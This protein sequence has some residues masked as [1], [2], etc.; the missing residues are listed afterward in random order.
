VN[1]ILYS[2]K[3][4]TECVKA[5]TDRLLQSETP[6]RPA[7]DGVVHKNGKFKL[8]IEQVVFR[9]LKRKTWIE[10]QMSKDGGMTIIRG[11]VPEGLAPERQKFVAALIPLAGVLMVMRGELLLA[12]LAMGLIGYV[13]LTLRGDYFNSDRLLVELEK[14]LRASPKLP[15]SAMNS[16]GNKP[17]GAKNK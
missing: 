11:Q 17:L 10:G 7:L 5:L 1:F 16:G 4:L 6:T 8:S 14:N 13:L 15:K 9:Q 2:E 12:L 3:P